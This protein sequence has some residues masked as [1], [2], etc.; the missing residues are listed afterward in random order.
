MEW[1]RISLSCLEVYLSNIKSYGVPKDICVVKEIMFSVYLSNIT[2]YGV[3]K[4]I[5]VVKE[6]M[7]SVYMLIIVE[8]LM[9]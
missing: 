4:D 9:G 6:I 2:S 3:S 1:L 7:F 8:L 5:C